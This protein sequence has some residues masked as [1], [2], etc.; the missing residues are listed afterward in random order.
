MYVSILSTEIP[1]FFAAFSKLSASARVLLFFLALPVINTA[2]F[3]IVPFLI[4]NYLIIL[5]HD[6]IFNKYGNI[7]MYCELKDNNYCKPEELWE[8]E[9]IYLR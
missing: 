9:K 5:K 7:Y 4:L 1:F 3:I 6:D 2:F 8:S